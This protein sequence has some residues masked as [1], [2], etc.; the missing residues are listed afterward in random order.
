M[1]YYIILICIIFL[2]C[3]VLPA[4]ATTIAEDD[5]N[6]SDSY[7]LGSKWHQEA[8]NF[9]QILDNRLV[10]NST[11]SYA[12]INQNISLVQ[13]DYNLSFEYVDL[14]LSS[15]TARLDIM[16]YLQ[17]LTSDSNGCMIELRE[18]STSAL[19]YWSNNSY[20]STPL[21]M[22]E[23]LK[24]NS[25]FIFSLNGTNVSVYRNDSYIG[26][27]DVWGDE[28]SSGTVGFKGLYSAG[29]KAI[30]DFIVYNDT[31][32]EGDTF[33]FNVTYWN[34]GSG[35]LVTTFEI[36]N[37]TA[38]WDKDIYVL[39]NVTRDTWKYTL[40]YSNDTEISNQTATSTNESLNFSIPLVEDSYNITES[41]TVSTSTIIVP[42]NS[43]CMF[44]N[45]TANTT[46]SAIAAN[47]SNDVAYSYYNVS[48][49]LWES[50]WPG[51]SWNT[52]NNIGEDNSVMAFFDAETTITAI[53][54]TPSST[55]LYT[56]WNML[57]VQ[58]TD[59]ETLTDIKADIGAN[60]TA[61]WWYDSSADTYSDTGAD[62]VQPNQGFLAYLTQGMT[63]TRS[64]L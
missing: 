51:Y 50:Y 47:E 46:F 43:W 31:A 10:L 8:A 33:D 48:S 27:I 14:N 62:T 7:N 63:W 36:S 57:F 18:D 13:S 23:T 45:W 38:G 20:I 6:R 12:V 26:F 64:D 40:S 61:I 4:T 54:I 34:P 19:A 44:N 41:A 9:Y 49:G 32:A 53:T 30:D 11:T 60:C 35:G 2:V 28:Y 29:E 42:A 59:N 3:C 52:N 24:N 5:F 39:L 58:N 15:Q 16:F 56:S 55:E 37:I 1:K 25:V 17:S 22:G 21:A